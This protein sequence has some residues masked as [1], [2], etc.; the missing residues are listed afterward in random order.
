[1]NPFASDDGDADRSGTDADASSID[2]GAPSTDTDEFSIEDYEAGLEAERSDAAPASSAEGP[3][4]PASIAIEN[5]SLSF[6]NLSVLEDVSLTVDAGEFVGF[7]GPN[8]AGKTTLLRAISSALEPDSGTIAVDGTD[9]HDASSSASSRLISVVPQDTSLS[10]SFPVRDVVAMGRHPHRSRFRAPTDEDRA[11]VDRALERTRTTEL[12][13]RPIDEVSGGQRQRVVLARAIAQETPVMLLDEPTAS[14]DVN[15]QIE[16]LEL[17]RDLV[18]DGQTVCA[19]IHDLDLAARYC[20]RLVL[21]ADGSVYRSG[22]PEDVLTSE[23]LSAV[24]EASATVTQNPI[25]GTEQV[26][27]LP[28]GDESPE[29]LEA[30]GTSEADER[31]PT[32]DRASHT[33][34]NH[35]SEDTD[36]GGD[37]IAVHVLGT[38]QVSAGIVS[39][40]E[41]AKRDLSVTVGPV[42][43]GSTVA[44]IARR[45]D[46]ACLEIDPYESPSPATHPTF[47]ERVGTAD[48]TIVTER[49]VESVGPGSRHLLET[50]DTVADSVVIVTASREDDGRVSGTW[51][52]DSRI[53]STPE[54]DASGGDYPTS[55]TAPETFSS[56]QQVIEATRETVLESID[57]A[58]E[59]HT[60][61]VDSRRTSG[62]ASSGSTSEDDSSPG[63]SAESSSD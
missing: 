50:V 61:A 2:A 31:T 63:A 51:E 60:N 22:P 14:L 41:T 9:V 40:L 44:D 49:V 34:A 36:D 24:F 13:D 43:R 37:S 53:G 15:H 46:L 35:A 3:P 30:G 18:D 26:T 16:T 12:A 32:A 11:A 62:S 56:H 28:S 27:A 21:L 38:G 58:R 6:G 45:H 7:I 29:G 10:F 25:T 52:A 8:G 19:A 59:E 55:R 57:A 5:C 42:T 1:M 23:T 4:E 17:V 33:K 39:R 54:D 48:V 20:D 47:E